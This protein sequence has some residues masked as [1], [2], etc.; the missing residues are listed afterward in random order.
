MKNNELQEEEEE[1]E[2]LVQFAGIW[3]GGGF[4]EEHNSTR[5]TD[6]LLQEI[7]QFCSS[8]GEIVFWLS[9][10][11][12]VRDTARL[13]R[14]VC[15]GRDTAERERDDAGETKCL[16]RLIRDVRYVLLFSPNPTKLPTFPHFFSQTRFCLIFFEASLMFFFFF[17]IRSRSTLALRRCFS[18][19]SR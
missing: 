3:R 4:A 10:P 16:V 14:F 11:L 2:A 8:Q 19:F 18:S 15:T 17:F 6:F 13:I 9:F 1:E 5:P 12:F 7:R